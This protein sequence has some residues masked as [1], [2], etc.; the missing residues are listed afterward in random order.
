MDKLRVLIVD[1]EK[2]IREGLRNVIDW[3]QYGY[4]VVGQA[5]NGK[6][7]LEYITSHK[8]D[9]V[10]S[11]ILMPFMDGLEMASRLFE[12][13]QSLYI[14]FI[15]GH[16]D[17]PY[18]QKAVRLG[19]F[20]YILKPIQPDELIQILNRIKED[21]K[22]L[23]DR[24]EV[25]QR[26][27]S[28]KDK[29]KIF[30]K[31][32][33]GNS[34]IELRDKWKDIKKTDS[35]YLVLLQL[36]RYYVMLQ[37]ITEQQKLV[38]LDEKTR[39]TIEKVVGNSAEIIDSGPGEYCLV[40]WNNRQREAKEIGEA[41][42]EICKETGFSVSAAMGDY[43][44]ELEQI[45]PAYQ[46]AKKMMSYRFA[47]GG[48][49]LIEKKEIDIG[50]QQ[51][52][53]IFDS[54]T[55]RQAVMETDLEGVNNELE[56][57]LI[58]LIERGA[59]S[60]LY[61]QM[62]ISEIFVGIVRSA[63][64]MGANIEEVFPDLIEEYK[65]VFSQATAECILEEFR[66]LILQIMDYLKLKKSGEIKELVK[67]G[68]RYIDNHF[69]NADLSMRLVATELGISPGYFSTEFKNYVGYTFTDY[70]TLVR[71]QRSTELLKNTGLRIYEVAERVGYPNST[72]FSTL[73][74]REKGVSPAEYRKL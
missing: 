17:F 67:K 13:Y 3:E 48:G 65:N 69:G 38:R 12:M 72:Y 4:T 45:K 39:E 74:K 53:A 54:S 47:E 11:D 57:L 9:I 8:V 27:S 1:D 56:R 41:V 64:S 70:L 21:I 32:L 25:S 19:A 33:E 50:K 44:T 20:D 7:A 24:K 28:S 68:K 63:E 60:Y 73:F 10:F 5:E 34:E 62:I 61:T 26:I 51:K 58:S 2:L 46:A 36:D 37:D 52:N 16:D 42:V 59:K 31:I 43:V 49:K 71:V 22:A 23:G 55:L 14:V 35:F 6:S 66:K 30:Q 29:E 15:S 40:L 18:V